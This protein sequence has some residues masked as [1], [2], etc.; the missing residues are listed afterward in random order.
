MGA[1][2]R[3]WP[4]RRRGTGTPAP[5]WWCGCNWRPPGGRRSLADPEQGRPG[6]ELRGLTRVRGQPCKTGPV[7]GGSRAGHRHATRRH[8]AVRRDGDAIPRPVRAVRFGRVGGGRCRAE[9]A[10]GRAYR[11]GPAATTGWRRTRPRCV[12]RSTTSSRPAPRRPNPARWVGSSPVGLGS[13][14]RDRRQLALEGACHDIEQ[15][16]PGR[17]A[18]RR[19]LAEE[20]ARRH[21]ARHRGDLRSWRADRPA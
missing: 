11:V 21:P 7:I 19:A 17:V 1:R 14:R 4:A 13:G 16:N 15:R 20:P 3:R 18:Q 10:G 8:A 9:P 2:T 6:R 5:C 12:R